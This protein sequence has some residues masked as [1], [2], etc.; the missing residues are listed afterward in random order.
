MPPSTPQTPAAL[1]SPPRLIPLPQGSPNTCV[2]LTALQHPSLLKAHGTWSG[3]NPCCFTGCFC[4]SERSSSRGTMF[5]FLFCSG[6]WCS[7]IH[8]S[9]F[10]RICTWRQTTWRPKGTH[11]TNITNIA[12]FHHRLGYIAHSDWDWCLSVTPLNGQHF[13]KCSVDYSMLVV[14]VPSQMMSPFWKKHLVIWKKHLHLP[15]LCSLHARWGEG[16]LSSE[17]CPVSPRSHQT[18]CTIFT[19]KVQRG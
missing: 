12:K 15:Q 4:A 19:F 16:P 13:L 14:T 3:P 1:Q 9:A 6:M 2:K 5:I 7:P 11:G 8:S 17:G 18:I 10:W